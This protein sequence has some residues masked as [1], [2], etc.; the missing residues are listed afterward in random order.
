MGLK[1]VA[2]FIHGDESLTGLD[3]NLMKIG[4][5]KVCA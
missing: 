2:A 3:H 1:R 4:L 5:V